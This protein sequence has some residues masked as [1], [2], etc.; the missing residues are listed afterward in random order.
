MWSDY[1]GSAALFY[2]RALAL[3]KPGVALSQILGRA[4]A[5]EIVHLLLGTTSH[6][7]LGL[8][9]GEWTA[10]DLR[11]NES[12]ELTR[13]GMAAIR[14]AVELRLALVDTEAKRGQMGVAAKPRAALPPP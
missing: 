13:A 2:D 9:K 5:H 12:L 4:M 10:E 8:M 3:R 11:F 6:T 7:G 1:G 14:D